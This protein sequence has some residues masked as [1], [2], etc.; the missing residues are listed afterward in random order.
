[1]NGQITKAE[2]LTM[3]RT[4]RAKW[5]RLLAQIPATWLTEP[6]V[7]G[8]WSI[9]DIIAHITWGERENIGVVRAHAVVGSELWQLSEDERNAA[10]FAQNRARSLEEVLSESSQV[11]AEYAAA[12][13]SLSEEELNDPSGFPGIPPGWRPWRIL[14]DPTHYEEHGQSIAAWLARRR[15]SEG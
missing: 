2:L 15:T 9:K 7:A 5:E 13:G 10:V 3:I 14:Y 1:M 8:G 11:F 6:G 4:A 12:V